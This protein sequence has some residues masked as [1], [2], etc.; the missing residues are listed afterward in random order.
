M[1]DT[2]ILA[3]SNHKNLELAH[4]FYHVFQEKNLNPTVVDLVSLDLPLYT[5][6]TEAQAAPKAI[7]QLCMQCMQAKQF[8]FITPEYNGGI[9][10]ALTNAIAWISRSE[11]ADWRTVFNGKMAAMG[12]VSGG[13]GLHALM[14]LRM[15]LAYIGLTVLGRQVIVNSHKPLNKATIHDIGN[16][17]T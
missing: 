3:G 2:L 6:I 1:S 10:P 14:A 4:E 17:F 5:P 9:A 7:H 15:Q 13:G 12:S 16:Q 8:V 11:S